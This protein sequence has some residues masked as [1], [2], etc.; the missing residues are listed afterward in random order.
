MFLI[1]SYLVNA[2]VS[3]V[4][5]LLYLLLSKPFYCATAL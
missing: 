5:L 2:Q 1:L 4:S 3:V